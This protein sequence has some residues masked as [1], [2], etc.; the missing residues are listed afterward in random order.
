M[1]GPGGTARG[2]ELKPN[3]EWIQRTYGREVWTE[4]LDR[5]AVA[6]QRR[7]ELVNVTGRYPTSLED[8]ISRALVEVMFARDPRAAGQA[9]REMGRHAADDNLIGAPDVLRDVSAE[10]TL[11]WVMTLLTNV[12]EEA[13][14]D[15]RT[16]GDTTG[17]VILIRSLGDVAYAGPRLCGW[18]ERALERRGL[19]DVFVRERNWEEGRIQADPLEIVVAW[20]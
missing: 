15:L 5:L 20:S 4:V 13:T 8:E 2:V 18:I 9:F 3:L 1:P 17:G 14:A 19:S 7:V 16:F 12:Y 11:R 10:A 6:D